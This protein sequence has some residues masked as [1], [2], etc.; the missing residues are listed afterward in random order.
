[1]K[2]NEDERKDERNLNIDTYQTFRRHLLWK[3][4]IL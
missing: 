2:T 1:M 3:A 4:F